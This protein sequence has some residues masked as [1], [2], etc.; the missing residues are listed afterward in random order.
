MAQY[1]DSIN[2]INSIIKLKEQYHM[3]I[4]LDIEKVFDKIEHHFMLK[5]LDR[6][7]I[8]GTY[9]NITKS[10][11]SKPLANIKLNGEKLDTIPLKSG[12]DR[13]S[14][15]SLPIQYDTGSSSQSNYTMNEGQRETN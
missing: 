8:Q 12:K 2:V 5:V 3:I 1:K 6:S 7:E 13:L 14:N 4:S 11:C 10:V 15:L 9:I